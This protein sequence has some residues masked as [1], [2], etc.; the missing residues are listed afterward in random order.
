MQMHKLQKNNSFHSV[1][2]SIYLIYFKEEQK[3]IACYI[4]LYDYLL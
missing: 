4:I 3:K 2:I 1:D